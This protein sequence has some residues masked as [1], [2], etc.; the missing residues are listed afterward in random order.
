VKKLGIGY[1]VVL[2]AG[3]IDYGYKLTVEDFDDLAADKKDGDKKEKPARR[4]PA[5]PMGIQPGMDAMGGAGG[6]AGAVPMK[7]IEAPRFDFIVQFCWQA[8][9]PDQM[10]KI[11]QEIPSGAPIVEDAAADEAAEME[12]GAED[13]AAEDGEEM[14]DEA[15]V[16]PQPDESAP[17]EG[18][19]SPPK[20]AA[21]E[22][23]DRD[24]ANEEA[25]KPKE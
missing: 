22:P 4:G 2:D 8:P 21:E 25:A 15:E 18:E 20:K 12:E 13:K 23:A 1:P 11:A 14:P 5:S 16:K 7:K 17:A 24:A 9:S 10:A 6:A 3:N 19:A